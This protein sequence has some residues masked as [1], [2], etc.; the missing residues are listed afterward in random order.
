MLISPCL[1]FSGKAEQAMRFYV[2]VFN[3]SAILELIRYGHEEEKDR[4][5][6]S[7]GVIRIHNQTILR[8][9]SLVEHN[10]SFTPS[11]SL[12]I[13][14]GTLSELNNVHDALAVNGEVLMS[15][16]TYQR[17]QHMVWYN[18]QFGVSW[19]LV[20]FGEQRLYNNENYVIIS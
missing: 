20:Y 2:S 15:L 10:F 11:T 19:Q 6:I 9:D 12:V 1:M 17:H 14:C 18:D 5:K 3:E 8:F 4:D 13:E 16:D 7:R